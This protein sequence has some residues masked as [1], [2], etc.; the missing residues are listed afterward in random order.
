MNKNYLKALTGSS[1]SLTYSLTIFNN[2]S[3]VIHLS[4]LFNV[5]IKRFNSFLQNSE[6]YHLFGFCK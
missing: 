2:L 5:G 3:G 4:S 1:R 6:Q